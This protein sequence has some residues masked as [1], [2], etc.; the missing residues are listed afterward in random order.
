MSSASKK[1]MSNLNEQAILVHVPGVAKTLGTLQISP[2]TAF[3]LSRLDGKT[4]LAT[5]SFMS[6]MEVAKAIELL[7]PLV[8][9]GVL[10][11]VGVTQSEKKIGSM[12]DLLEHEESD[13]KYSKI[14]RELRREVLLL[15]SRLPEMNHF[16]VL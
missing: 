13:P 1:S 6:G 7:K 11:V 14:P 8:N 5:I 16:E 3:L 12:L 15:F 4:D 2:E 9:R 10:K